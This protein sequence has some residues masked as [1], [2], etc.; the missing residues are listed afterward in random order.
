[1][2][3]HGQE[4]Y[5][6]R[7]ELKSSSR[8]TGRDHALGTLAYFQIKSAMRGVKFIARVCVWNA[9]HSDAAPSMHESSI[10]GA[11]PLVSLDGTGRRGSLMLVNNG[12][13]G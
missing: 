3:Y 9:E 8:N 4:E 12:T 2:V 5:K 1:L 11:Y 10:Y 6:A 7:L 13:V